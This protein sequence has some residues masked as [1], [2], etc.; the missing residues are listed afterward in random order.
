[1]RNILTLLTLLT[2]LFTNAQDT[3]KYKLSYDNSL[4]GTY[5]KNTTTT[6][7][8][9]YVGS[10]SI[11]INKIGISSNTS[12]LIGLN[13]KISQNEFNHKINIGLNRKKSFFFITHQYNYSFLRKISN[14]NLIGLGGGIFKEFSESKISL[15]YGIIYEETNYFSSTNEYT[16]RHSIRGK[17]LYDLKTLIFSTEYY[18]QPSMIESNIVINGNTKISLKIN[19]YINLTIQDVVNYSSESSVPM[20]HNLTLGLNY[21]YKNTKT[22]L[23]H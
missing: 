10:N 6:T 21:T 13:P 7:I 9:S 22:S 3:I 14:E 4:T 15:S 2:F 1:M 17:I 23:K 20:I 8:L 16:L 12:Y 18:Y 11:N 19:K 5:S